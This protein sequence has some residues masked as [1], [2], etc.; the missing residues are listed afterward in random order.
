[1]QQLQHMQLPLTFIVHLQASMSSRLT[2]HLKA[3]ALLPVHLSTPA[4]AS[5]LHGLHTAMEQY[6]MGASQQGQQATAPALQVLYTA[7]LQHAL[8]QMLNGA[9]ASFAALPVIG[10]TDSRHE[11]RPLHTQLWAL[12]GQVS[13]SHTRTDCALACVCTACSA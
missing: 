5:L 11:D 4:V 9:V 8:S 13:L 3:L 12:L 1:M 10:R 7:L 6:H 2:A